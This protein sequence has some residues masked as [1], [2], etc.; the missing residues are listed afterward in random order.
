M[1]ITENLNEGLSR[2]YTLTATAEEVDERVTEKLKELGVTAQVKGFR[3][4]KAPVSVLRRIYGKRTRA[5]V[6]M[7]VVQKGINDHLAKKDE[8]PVRQPKVELKNSPD[9]PDINIEFSYECTPV[10]PEVDLSSIRIER[11]D[12]VVDEKDVTEALEEYAG[13]NPVYAERRDDEGACLEDKVVVSF[14][15]TVDET[16]VD[17]LNATDFPVIIGSETFIPGFE[18]QLLGAKAGDRR[19]VE[20]T[21][22]SNHSDKKIAGKQALFDCEISEISC[23]QT[24]EINQELAEL[25]GFDSLDEMKGRVRENLKFDSARIAE[26]I[27]KARLLDELVERLDFELPPDVLNDEIDRVRQALEQPD[28]GEQAEDPTGDEAGQNA[29]DVGQENGETGDS[30]G[31]EANPEQ[32]AGGEE[33][34]G[35]PGDPDGNSGESDDELHRIAVR[36]L[37]TGFLFSQ[38]A[39]EQDISVSEGDMYKEYSTNYRLVAPNVW[40]EQILPNRQWRDTLYGACLEKKVADWVLSQVNVTEKSASLDEI[41]TM[42][43]ALES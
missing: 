40:K 20:V 17:R 18:Q 38:L 3:R 28:A 31:N 43:R 37:R 5:S 14:T 9:D 21:I 36:R 33:S 13:A 16:P 8:K 4:G 39:K 24:R 19:T 7:E 22:P 11:P 23:P 25:L 1:E 12:P 10:I 29:R 27:A 30:A 34:P 2:S 32:V 41:A 6:W 42:S 15:A 35:S 26:Q